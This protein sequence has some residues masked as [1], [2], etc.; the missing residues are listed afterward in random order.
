MRRY[1]IVPWIL[2]ILSIIN[3]TLAA[4]VVFQEIRHA[5][6]DQVDVREDAIPAS[7]SEKRGDE[8]ERLKDES[9]PTEHL[10]R[11]SP[12]PETEYD[13][14]PDSVNSFQ[15][16]ASEF[17]SPEIHSDVSSVG[18]ETPLVHGPGFVEPMTVVPQKS[19]LG[20]WFSKS[21]GFLSKLVSKTKNLFGKL[22]GKLKFWRRASSESVS[23]WP[24]RGSNEWGP[25]G[26]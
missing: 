12:P 15:T 9:P 3:A 18:S 20:E 11:S 26:F 23:A 21:K 2:L 5:Y 14:A 4:P 6:I 22:A 10:R 19:F 24:R 8:S 13:S 7:R 17:R 16:G 25:E 1:K